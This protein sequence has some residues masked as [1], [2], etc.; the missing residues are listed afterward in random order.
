[1]KDQKF[2]EQSLKLIE[3]TAAWNT[4][5]V[6]IYKN[7]VEIH[8]EQFTYDSDLIKDI[9]LKKVS[10]SG[11]E[12]Y[13]ECAIQSHENIKPNQVDNVYFFALNDNN[14]LNKE[15]GMN[16][17]VFLLLNGDDS[18]VW[19]GSKVYMRYMYGRT[20]IDFNRAKDDGL[21][22]ADEESIM[23]SP[24]YYLKTPTTNIHKW[25]NEELST[26]D[27]GFIKYSYAYYGGGLQVQDTSYNKFDG[28]RRKNQSEIR[29]EEDLEDLPT[30]SEVK[31]M[32]RKGTDQD[33]YPKKAE[34]TEYFGHIT[35][36]DAITLSNIIKEKANS[37]KFD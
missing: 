36:G 16:N 35:V 27:V 18:Y 37:K 28:Q 14:E 32:Y 4:N 22:K 17:V 8:G 34:K 19:M 3:D 26:L 31:W 20:V 10:D 9:A 15:H 5:P 33:R 11:N 2:Y 29:S 21:I 23:N 1:M 7:H 24:L 12:K 25:T 6:N 13:L 30:V